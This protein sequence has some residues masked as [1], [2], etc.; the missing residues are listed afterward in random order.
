VHFGHKGWDKTYQDRHDWLCKNC[1]NRYA[2]KFAECPMCGIS[3]ARAKLVVQLTPPQDLVPHLH[4]RE[5]TLESPEEEYPFL[6]ELVAR[7]DAI[8]PLLVWT[9]QQFVCDNQCALDR[10]PG[11]PWPKDLADAPTKPCNGEELIVRIP[12]VNLS[13]VTPETELEGE[14][15]CLSCGHKDKQ[16]LTWAEWKVLREVEPIAWGYMWRVTEP[17]IYLD[18]HKREDLIPKRTF[19]LDTI[20]SELA[21]PQASIEQAKPIVSPVLADNL[22]T[23]STPEASKALDALLAPDFL[24]LNQ[25]APVSVP[26]V[27]N[28]KKSRGRPKK[29]SQEA[30][31]AHQELTSDL[32]GV[33]DLLPPSAPAGAVPALPALP[34]GPAPVVVPAP[35]AVPAVAPVIPATPP[36]VAPKPR[37]SGGSLPNGVGFPAQSQA[38]A[39]TN[40]TVGISVQA[41]AQVCAPVAAQS[42]EVE[43]AVQEVLKFE[44]LPLDIPELSKEL[45]VLMQGWPLEKLV[46]EY[47]TL[48]GQ[49]F[50]PNQTVPDAM[51]AAV[52]EKLVSAVA[53]V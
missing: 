2:V 35:Q 24:A 33:L 46:K 31:A 41:K 42:A 6:N 29:G 49:K 25:Q 11:Q 34:T 27:E 18:K 9:T 45:Q 28:G 23:R 38:Q 1:T 8:N 37:A 26:P 4:I 51:T 44:P 7:A 36:T 52:I 30:S 39:Q 12:G 5:V 21:A 15:Q 32:Q 13:K 43:K 40:Q 19:S 17:V 10:A 16:T 47:E 48:T 3:N 22:H 20:W 14:Y 50:V 53:P